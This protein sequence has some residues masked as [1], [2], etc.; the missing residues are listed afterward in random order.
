MIV[1]ISVELSPPTRKFHS[2]CSADLNSPAGSCN[3]SNVYYLPRPEG[4]FLSK[5]RMNPADGSWTVPI[6]NRILRPEVQN[7]SLADIIESSA[8][9]MIVSTRIELC[10]PNGKCQ[11][12]TMEI[13]ILWPDVESFPSRIAFSDWMLG[14]CQSNIITSYNR[15]LI[16][17]TTFEFTL[18]NRT[19][20][21]SAWWNSIL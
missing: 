19:F 13:S 2:F 11:A 20:Q 5:R 16:V 3:C 1:S 17:S 9:N 7:F 12:T 18:S 21:S 8:R 14:M 6:M 10:H 4:G 15:N